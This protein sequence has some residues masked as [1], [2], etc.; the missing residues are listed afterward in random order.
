MPRSPTSIVRLLP[1]SQ[2][3]D[4]AAASA[5][6]GGWAPVRELAA[7]FGTSL[8][9]MIVRLEKGAWA[10]RDANGYPRSG[11]PKVESPQLVLLPDE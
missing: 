1:S 4:A 2:R 5:P 10:H 11:K 9:A 7:Y 3:H 8:T 6:W